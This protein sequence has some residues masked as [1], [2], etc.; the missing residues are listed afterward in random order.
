M[1]FGAV[2]NKEVNGDGDFVQTLIKDLGVKAKCQVCNEDWRSINKT[3]STNKSSPSVST[4]EVSGH[5]KFDKSQRKQS[6]R[7]NKCYRGFHFVREKPDQRVVE[8]SSRKKYQTVGLNIH[9]ESSRE[10]F[11]RT[12]SQED[13]KKGGHSL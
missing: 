2:E 6:L 5:S 8:K 1:V 3:N 13:G 10:S 4:S 12:L 7:R 9:L 11:E